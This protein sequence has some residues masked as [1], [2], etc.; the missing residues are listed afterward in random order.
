MGIRGPKLTVWQHAPSNR[1]S[2]LCG[3]LD[4][5]PPEMVEGKEHTAAVDLWALGVL[6]YEFVVGGPPF[7]VSYCHIM[8]KRMLMPYI[9]SLWKRR[10]IP[11]NKEC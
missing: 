8:N 2:T 6:T 7:E 3:T 9:G 5:L 11:A 4:Y 10:Y 1:R